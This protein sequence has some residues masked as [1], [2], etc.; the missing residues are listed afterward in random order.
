MTLLASRTDK[1]Q[2]LLDPLTTFTSFIHLTTPFKERSFQDKLIMPRCVIHTRPG[3]GQAW[4]NVLKWL[5]VCTYHSGTL[6]G[7]PYEQCDI[8]INRVVTFVGLI[9]WNRSV[10]EVTR[11]RARRLVCT[12]PDNAEGFVFNSTVSR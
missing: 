6:L 4:Y 10:S 1:D 5:Y 12:S 2:T 3:G 8:C 11:L 7:S 9:I